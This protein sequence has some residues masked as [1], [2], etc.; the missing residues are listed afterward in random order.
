MSDR[1]VRMAGIAA[2]VF[3]VLVLATLVIS[4]QPPMADDS[5]GEIRDYFVDHRTAILLSN[6]LGLI[7]T[8][9]VVW[10]AVVFRHVVRGEEATTHALATASLAAVVLT[11]PMAMVGGALSSAPIYVDGV[12]EGLGDDAVRLVFEAQ[13]LV[14]AATGAG[15]VLFGLTAAMAVQRSGALPAYVTWLGFLVVVGNA[16]AIISVI[17]SGTALLGLAGVLTLVLF[18]L[19]TGVTMA[20]GKTRL[21]TAARSI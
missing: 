6:L 1:T 12:A 5:V 13:L 20:L 17:G 4:G 10:F 18:L 19:V 2:I 14:F 16:L 3:V 15:L 8:P 11:A 21:T 9:L 7:G